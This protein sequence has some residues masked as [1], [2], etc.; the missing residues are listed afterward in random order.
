MG[1]VCS[2]NKA[3]SPRAPDS[4][5]EAATAEAVTEA[6]K[7]VAAPEAVESAGEAA[8]A[9]TGGAAAVN[10]EDEVVVAVDEEDV[11]KAE[12][13][14]N[15]IDDAAAVVVTESPEPAA[16]IRQEKVVT[17]EGKEGEI[18]THVSVVEAVVSSNMTALPEKVE[19]VSPEDMEL[20]R[21]AHEQVRAARGNEEAKTKTPGKASASAYGYLVY[22]PEKGGSLILLWSKHE[23]TPEEEEKAGK[24]LLAFVPALH[25]TVPMKYEQKGNKTELL[26]GFTDKWN[27]WKAADKQ[28]YY[29]AWTK[30][31][32]TC[33]QYEAKVTVREWT[34]E[35]PPHVFVSLLYVG[36]LGNKV[37][38]MPEN[39]QMDISVFSQIAVVPA[40]KTKEFKPG[41][42]LSAKKFQ[43]F[44]TAVGGAYV[45]FVHRGNNAMMGQNDLVAWLKEDGLTVTEKEG[46]IR[47]D[48]IAR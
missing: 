8:A 29:A 3:E 17:E 12:Q 23:L 41:L 47:M 25:K 32:K 21:Q 6:V 18:R 28:K 36:P 38:N 22:V 1:G 4:V 9:T 30:V 39:Q 37:A 15:V 10:K 24:V 34:E 48:E 2:R 46:V 7:D 13:K 16:V 42:D 44:A 20:L 5:A 26:T 35:A 33:D 19:G 31:F 14:P 43:D 45:T 27:T 40:D 11:K